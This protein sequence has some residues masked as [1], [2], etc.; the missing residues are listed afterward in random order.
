MGQHPA[1]ETHNLYLQPKECTTAGESGIRD[2]LHD[3][4]THNNDRKA[5]H[6]RAVVGRLLSPHR[7]NYLYL[8]TN[9]P[10]NSSGN[11]HLLTLVHLG[12]IHSFLSCTH[13]TP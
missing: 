8:P 1:V 3:L 9:T 4:L 6:G 10:T 12:G 11:I 7:P 2:V 5:L 13:I